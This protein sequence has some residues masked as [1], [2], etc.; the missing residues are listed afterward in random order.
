ML[1]VEKGKPLQAE[2]KVNQL[3]KNIFPLELKPSY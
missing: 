3:L 2:K 1:T